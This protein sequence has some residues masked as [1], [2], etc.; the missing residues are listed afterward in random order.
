MVAAVVEVGLIAVAPPPV[1]RAPQDHL[2]KAMPAAAIMEIPQHRIQLV[3]VAE[4]EVL[5]TAH[6][7]VQPAEQEELDYHLLYQVLQQPM[8]AAVA[9]RCM[10][11]EPAAQEVVQLVVR[12]RVRV[13]A[14]VVL[15]LLI[16]EVAVAVV[17][18]EALAVLVAQ[19]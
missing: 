2:Y 11:A 16:P 12:G 5:V 14:V 13:G 6:L 10:L 4:L 3:A 7:E 8:Q 18:M 19:E 1:A 9:V 15:E 17:V